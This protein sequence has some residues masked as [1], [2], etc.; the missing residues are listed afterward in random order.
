MKENSD[1]RGNGGN[2][3]NI[4][5][6]ILMEVR[7]PGSITCPES[8][9][10]TEYLSL[11]TFDAN[12]FDSFDGSQVVVTDRLVLFWKPPGAFSQ[13]T[14]SPFEV[15]V[16]QYNCA[17]QYMMAEKA[18]LFGDIATE[19]RVLSTDDP[20]KQQRLGKEVAGFDGAIW[21]VHR[22]N[23]V[24]AGN[25]AK[26]T[27][28]NHLHRELIDTGGRLLVEASPM[29]IIWGIGFTAD[30]PEAYEP[31]QWRGQNLL[32]KVM[33]EVRKHLGGA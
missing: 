27:Q 25:V 17:E 8:S 33:M 6:Q 26:F 9:P 21:Q 19:R 13:W 31:E 14:P 32:G 12:A 22:Y 24:F 5:G 7:M 2:G 23:I 28:N 3:Q 11:D 4:L 20:R 18:R 29:D 15:G 1:P 16:I 30:R 10:M